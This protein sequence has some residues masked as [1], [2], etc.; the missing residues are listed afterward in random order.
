M[1]RLADLLISWGALGVLLIATLDSAGVPL[2]AAV[3]ALLITVA[4]VD[5]RQAYFAALLATLG[6]VAGN[7]FLHSMARKGGEAFLD[8]RTQSGRARKFRDWF[9]HYGL[10]T[11]FI[12]TF[13]PI[14]P[15]PLKVFV[16]SAGALGVSRKTFLLTILVARIPRFLAMAYLGSQLGEHSMS[17]LQEHSWHFG[18][19]A[20]AL[21]VFLYGLVRFVDWR[22]ARA[23]ASVSPLE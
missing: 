14:V 8:K 22:K 6:S 5:P 19:V 4:A 13:V 17:W 2:P 18:F 1:Q 7:F 11:V 12:P 10:I 3:D 9:H 23:A 15:L 20:V 16:F 21:A